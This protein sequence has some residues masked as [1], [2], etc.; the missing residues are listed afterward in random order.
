MIVLRRKKCK[1]FT[2][3]YVTNILQ[4][5]KGGE[6]ILVEIFYLIFEDVPLGN[7]KP[8]VIRFQIVVS[9]CLIKMFYFLA[10]NVFFLAPSK[11]N[12]KI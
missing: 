7:H 4:K 6:Y 10:L 9:S 8:I 11:C 12:R 1:T 5:K 3:F 2:T